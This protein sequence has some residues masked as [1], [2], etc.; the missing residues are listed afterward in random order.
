MPGL[1]S[2]GTH[3]EAAPSSQLSPPGRSVRHLG[4]RHHCPGRAHSARLEVRAA[5][6][7]EYRP[8][9]SVTAATELSALDALS[10]IVPDT[11]LSRS[12]HQLTRP[13]AATV[14]SSVL[15]GILRS[16]GALRELE[17]AIQRAIHYD[18]CS[19]LAGADKI[20]CQVDK[21]LANVGSLFA[22]QVEGRVSTEV[23]PRYA[24]SKEKIVARAENVVVQYRDLGVPPERVL[25]R[26][27][28]SWEGIQAAKALEEQ[29]IQTHIILVYSF[30]QAVA[31][32]QAGV[33]VLQPNLGLLGDW[34]RQHP[35]AIRDPKG[36]REDSGGFD[37]GDNPGIKLVERIYNYCQKLYPKTK[38]M[39]SGVRRKED[40]LA[41]A[42]VDFLVVGDKVLTELGGAS[43][44]Q[45]YNDGLKATGDDDDATVQPQLTVAAAQRAEFSQ[46]DLQPLS[47]ADYRAKLGQ[48]G[49]ELLD[50]G[51]RGLVADLGRLEETLHDLAL[52]SGE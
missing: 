16:P 24:F 52:G 39:V 1:R 15:Y 40:A 17:L 46:D 45:G 43:T 25:V 51:V 4:R 48:A 23:D 34:Y 14:S 38:V 50:H 49:Q 7:T 21:A 20:A 35:G 26:I 6:A 37:V 10:V 2:L 29:G 11:Y 41:L 27:P 36:P 13:R 44:M 22:N 32:A 30:A 18:R 28:G 12:L 42:G 3:R 47:E 31:A 9:S 33:S 5:T 19:T 8:P